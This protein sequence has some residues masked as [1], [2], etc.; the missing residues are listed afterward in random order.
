MLAF[1]LKTPTNASIA[2]AVLLWP[3]FMSCRECR[4]FRRRSMT[5]TKARYIDG[6]S[7]IEL[8]ADGRLF[9]VEICRPERVG[10]TKEQKRIAQAISEAIVKS[11][12]YVRPLG[13]EA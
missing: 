12:L 2:F 10:G 11:G 5:I 3:C 7:R 4:T 9:F 6:T 13:G 8:I 1:R